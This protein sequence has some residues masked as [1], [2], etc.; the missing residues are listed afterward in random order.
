MEHATCEKAK[1]QRKQTENTGHK[2]KG[3]NYEIEQIRKAKQKSD[4][5]RKLLNKMKMMMMN[6]KYSNVKET[7]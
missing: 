1:K 3:R 4:T 7:H 2:Q 5:K 6:K